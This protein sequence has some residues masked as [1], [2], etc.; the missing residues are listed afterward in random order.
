ME[1]VKGTENIVADFLSRPN[2]PV[3]ETINSIHLEVFDIPTLIEAQSTD[4]SIQNLMNSSTNF[5]KYRTYSQRLSV[6][7]VAIIFVL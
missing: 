4:D 5:K 2:N 1:Y 3:V 6:N 7:Q